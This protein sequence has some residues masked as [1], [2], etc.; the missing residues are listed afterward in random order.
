MFAPSQPRADGYPLSDLKGAAAAPPSFADGYVPRDPTA[1]SEP[2]NVPKPHASGFVSFRDAVA[3]KAP[4]V[5]SSKFPVLFGDRGVR[6][7][8]RAQAQAERNA[9]DRTA[10]VDLDDEF[11]LGKG[12]QPSEFVEVCLDEFVALEEQEKAQRRQT[13]GTTAWSSKK[14]PMSPFPKMP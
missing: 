13:E 2:S 10:D 1:R 5:A 4:I 7:A 14:I 3:A 9:A 8:K 12:K 6:E 11:G